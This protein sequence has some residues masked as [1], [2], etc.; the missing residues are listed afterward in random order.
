V[1]FEHLDEFS[2]VRASASD[3]LCSGA[4]VGNEGWPVCRF[5]VLPTFENCFAWD[6]RSMPVRS[7]PAEPRLFRSCWRK[8]LDLQALGSPV[9]RLK[10]PRPYRPTVEVGSVPID[11]AKI[12]GLVH[13]FQRIPVPLGVAEPPSGCDGTNYDLEIG[14]F[15]CQARIAWWVHLPEE[16]AALG[17]LIEE[18]AALFES[19]WLAS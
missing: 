4:F 11:A 2:A 16:W 8:D 10:H 15:F 13:R 5:V 19:S 18:L 6:V 17:P 14:H 3:G 12:E 1:D 9:E 7:K